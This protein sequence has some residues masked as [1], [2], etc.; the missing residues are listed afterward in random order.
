MEAVTVFLDADR[1]LTRQAASRVRPGAAKVL[2]AVEECAER[3]KL[4]CG[5]AVLMAA[6]G[7]R[8]G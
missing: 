3:S 8:R 5:A 6:A 2:S 7:G 4:W 1:R